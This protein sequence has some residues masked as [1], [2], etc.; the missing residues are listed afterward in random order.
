MST[1][2]K[3]LIDCSNFFLDKLRENGTEI[4]EGHNFDWPNY[5]FTSSKFRRA[6]LDIVDAR[7]TKK[8]YMMHLC[9]FPHTNDTS[10]IYGFDLIAGPTK[11]TGAFHDFSPIVYKNNY[12]VRHFA[13][14]V[15]NLEWSKKRELP[16]W[17]MNIFSDNMIAAGNIQKEEELESILNIAKDNLTYYLSE[18]GNSRGDKDYTS[19]QNYYCT[20]QKKN[21][22]TPRVMTTLGLDENDVKKFIETCLFPSVHSPT[23][24]SSHQCVKESAQSSTVPV[25]LEL[26]DNL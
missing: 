17:A 7:E 10:P 12:M 25:Q 26:W 16:D 21:P 3:N 18:V 4:D 1:I 8:L 9:V 2:F 23:V 20:N 24:P 6:H 13:E 19:A 15:K 22:H 5:V 11:I 14:K